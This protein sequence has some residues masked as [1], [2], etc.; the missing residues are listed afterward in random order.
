MTITLYKTNDN[1]DTL[2]NSELDETYH[3]R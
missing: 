1:S 2:Y 3:S